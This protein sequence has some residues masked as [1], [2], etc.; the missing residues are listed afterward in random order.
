MVRSRCDS[1]HPLQEDELLVVDNNGLSGGTTDVMQIDP[2]TPSAPT[3]VPSNNSFD[4]DDLTNGFVMTSSNDILTSSNNTDADDYVMTMSP[5]GTFTEETMDLP[6]LSVDPSGYITNSTPKFDVIVTP[7][8]NNHSVATAKSST[9]NSYRT[10][11][12]QNPV[13]TDNGCTANN[14]THTLQRRPQSTN[15][16]ISYETR[17]VVEVT[18]SS[19]SAASTPIASP[20]TFHTP[21]P[22]Q[23]HVS[24]PTP[25]VQ[26]RT[27]NFVGVPVSQLTFGTSGCDPLASKTCN[28][29]SV[30]RAEGQGGQGSTFTAVAI[31]GPPTYGP[32]TTSKGKA[33]KAAQTCKQ[34]QQQ[35]LFS[36]TSRV[37]ALETKRPTSTTNTTNIVRIQNPG[38]ITI[39]AVNIESRVV[40]TTIQTSEGSK[41]VAVVPITLNLK[42]CWNIMTKPER[43]GFIELLSNRISKTMSLEVSS[44]S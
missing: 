3:A 38:P 1:G 12:P 17:P 37:P 5:T 36:S 7:S 21:P 22:P 34:H 26:T 6:A 42:G 27:P 13:A 8:N 11:S 25:T 43:E 16:L 24:I 30:V 20:I 33:S 10:W 32:S 31:P 29:F 9:N 18:T 14:I 28:T 23:Q 19:Y 15:N 4:L 44:S 2:I 40:Q 41:P 35:S 39:P